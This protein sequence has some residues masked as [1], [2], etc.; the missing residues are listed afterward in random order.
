MGTFL[1]E[2]AQAKRL[3]YICKLRQ[4]KP[5]MDAPQ[6]VEVCVRVK[7][8]VGKIYILI[9]HSS[10]PKKVDIPWEAHEYLSGNT[11][12]GQLTLTPYGVAILTKAQE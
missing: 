2:E 10:E 3:N 12:K 7:L 11:G 4:V 8:D 1:A 6:G 5:A 9:N